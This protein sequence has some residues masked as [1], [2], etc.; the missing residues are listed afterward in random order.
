M[1]KKVDPGVAARIA[2]GGGAGKHPG[3]DGVRPT[4]SFLRDFLGIGGSKPPDN[5]GT[6]GSGTHPK[7]RGD[8]T[9][10]DTARPEKTHWWW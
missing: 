2:S 5:I 3:D 8:G 10:E 6:R 1:S 9:S 7:G 4:P